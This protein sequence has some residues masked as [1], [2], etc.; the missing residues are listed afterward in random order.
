MTKNCQL[1]VDNIRKGVMPDKMI[2]Y[3]IL[4]Y[5]QVYYGLK[6]LKKK[7]I[8]KMISPGVWEL[9]KEHHD[10][11]DYTPD[12][13]KREVRGHG[14][15]A[16]LRVNKLKNW[17]R[18]EF[19]MRRAGIQFDKIPQGQKIVIDDVIIWLTKK[20]IVFYL[21]YSWFGKDAY[22]CYDKSMK[23]LLSL[24]ADV[25]KKLHVTTFKIN[26][27]YNLRFAR[28]H[29]A[30]VQN[31]LAKQYNKDHK[32]LRVYDNKGLWLEIDNSL[33]MNELETFRTPDVNKVIQDSFNDMKDGLTPRFL[34]ERID[35]VTK[36]QELF[37]ENMKS[38]IS[39]IQELA[40]G[41]K[42]LRDAVKKLRK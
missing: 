31:A 30:L 6:T 36:N 17:H 13:P 3:K 4:T 37:A 25:E 27:F 34:A 12:K 5:R 35:D 18:R 38:H 22:E 33:N 28:Q 19:L 32:K 15:T 10:G 26:G 2:K 11:M 14:I 1:I 8:V 16:I 9:T 29:W 39:A 24:I 21:P 42:E 40:Q 41:V 23:Y 7:G 20:T